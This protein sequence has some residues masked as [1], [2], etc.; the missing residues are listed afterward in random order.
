MPDRAIVGLRRG[1]LKTKAVK[2]GDDY[3]VSG[4][5]AFISGG[6]EARLRDDGRTGEDGPK[7]ITALVVEKDMKGVS[8]GANEKK[9]GIP[10]RPRRSISTRCACPSPTASAAKAKAFASP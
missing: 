7:G 1:S 9:L 4:S 8:F 5:K 2:D 3:V 10:S 6:G